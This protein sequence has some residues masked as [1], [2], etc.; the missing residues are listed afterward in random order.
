MV[1]ASA[2]R[3]EAFGARTRFPRGLTQLSREMGPY[4]EG[5]PAR[6]PTCRWEPAQ[7]LRAV[8]EYGTFH[9]MWN[10][11][12]SG[13]ARLS[14]ESPS[15]SELLNELYDTLRA[16]LPPSWEL[17]LAREVARDSQR[18]NAL[19]VAS[20]PDGQRASILI[21]VRRHLDPQDV[22]QVADQLRRAALPGEGLLVVAPFLSPRTRERLEEDGIGYDDATGNFRLALDQP[23]VFIELAGA[24]ANPWRERR[25]PLRSLKGPAAGRT[26]RALCDFRPPY[27]VSELAGRS[28]TPASSI[29]RVVTL[30]ER[31]SLLTRGTFGEV[32]DVKWRELIQRWTQDY[33]LTTSNRASTFLEPRG[34]EALLQKLKGAAW[35]YAVTGSFAAVHVAPIAPPRLAVVYIQDRELAASSLDLRRAERGAN[36]LLVEPFDAVVFDRTTE[37]DGVTYAALSQVAA[38][39]LTSP[40][41]GPQEG[42]ELLRWMEEHEDA[43]RQ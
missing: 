1:I 23:A 20:A 9:V 42:Q 39:L 18:L 33:G 35:Q 27:G 26:V 28:K 12:I 10:R 19:L 40:G 41:R 2:C 6:S 17:R 15:E 16:R 43:W 11:D 31:Q 4:E 30:L 25:A 21:E 8:P 13:T 14:D 3:L 36:V 38:D 7:A 24:A 34:L 32:L 37:R 5:Q 22:P 29:S